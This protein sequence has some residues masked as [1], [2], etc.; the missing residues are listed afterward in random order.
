MSEEVRTNPPTPEEINELLKALPTDDQRIEAF[1]GICRQCG[2]V[3]DESC[4]C[5]Y[6]TP[7]ED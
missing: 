4:W 5:D 1:K 6:E 2:K 3:T 7:W